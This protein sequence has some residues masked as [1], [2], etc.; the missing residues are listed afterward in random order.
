MT[1]H[2]LNIVVINGKGDCGKDSVANVLTQYYGG[3]NIS[4]ITPVVNLLKAITNGKLNTKDIRVRRVLS[5]MKQGMLA[6]CREY[7]SNEINRAFCNGDKLLILHIREPQEIDGVVRTFGTYSQVVDGA[8]HAINVIPLLVT[9]SRTDCI[10]YNNPSDDNCDQYPYS[11]IYKNDGDFENLE[12][13][14]LKFAK[15][16]MHFE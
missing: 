12:Q 8:Y 6:E 14:V 5:A 1:V 9:S 11:Y 3:E 10:E 7:C 16:V 4:S 13:D 2:K 15:E